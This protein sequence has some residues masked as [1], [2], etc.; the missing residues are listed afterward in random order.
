MNNFNSRLP[1]E[2][3]YRRDYNTQET[4]SSCRT[5]TPFVDTRM[6]RIR[7]WLRE[8]ASIRLTKWAGVFIVAFLLIWFVFFNTKSVDAQVGQM[9]WERQIEIEQFRTIDGKDWSG[10][11]PDDARV[12][13]TRSEVHH[14]DRVL[15]HYR[16]VTYTYSCG[17]TQ[18]PRTCTGTRSEP[19]YVS[20]PVYRDRLYYKVDRWVTD[21]WVTS[22][23]VEM[24]PYWPDLPDGLDAR[25]ILGNRR[26]GDARKQY[27][28]MDIKC[29]CDPAVIELNHNSWHDYKPG[30]KV[31][32]YVTITGHVR[33]VSVIKEE[34]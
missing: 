11:E 9:R 6:D 31:I 1:W 8:P 10:S 29:D 23:S 18:S 19:V 20:V 15:S 3:D 22:K 17:T 32:A 26:E 16:T 27:Y 2:P 21:S 28:E 33:G 13:D 5:V 30:Q 24:Q 25:N 7:A 4:N 12:Y 34:V 14:Y